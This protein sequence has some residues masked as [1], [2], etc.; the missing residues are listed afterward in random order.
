MSCPTLLPDPSLIHIDYLSATDDGVTLMATVVQAQP[1]C[2]DCQRPA[3]R[4]HSRYSRTLTDQPWK[5]LHVRLRLRTRRWFCD[6][7]NCSRQIFTERLP[8]FVHRYAH[9]TDRLA[10]ILRHLGMA[11]GGEAGARLA[12]ELGLAVSPD[13]LLRQVQQ[14]GS[15]SGAAPRV[16]GVDDILRAEALAALVYNLGGSGTW[17]EGGRC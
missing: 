11:L 9:R 7:P 4:V 1:R 16:L 17:M 10:R 6:E 13:T 15:F 2:P 14:A 5:S 8:G 3:Q 12:V